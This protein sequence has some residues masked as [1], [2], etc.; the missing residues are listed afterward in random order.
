[1]PLLLLTSLLSLLQPTRLP[2]YPRL[3]KLPQWHFLLDADERDEPRRRL[4]VIQYVQDV[5]HLVYQWNILQHFLRFVPQVIRKTWDCFH[6]FEN[7]LSPSICAV[8]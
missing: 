3:L 6:S 8:N 5:A 1:M 7:R 2:V 4:D